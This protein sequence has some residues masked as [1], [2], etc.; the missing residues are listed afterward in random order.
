MRP[1][2]D[3]ETQC[4]RHPL[5]KSSISLISLLIP[6]PARSQ[7][8]GGDH[9]HIVRAGVDRLDVVALKGLQCPQLLLLVRRVVGESLCARTRVDE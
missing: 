6:P 2:K 5:C 3:T 8:D 7:N 9:S 1:V 4:K